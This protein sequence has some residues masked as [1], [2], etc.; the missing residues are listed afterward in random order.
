MTLDIEDSDF[1]GDIFNVDTWVNIL[2]IY[3]E[4]YFDAIMTDGG[5]F[6]VKRDDFIVRIKQRLLKD[7][8]YIYNYT[9]VIGKQV[10]DPM[11]RGH[12]FYKIPKREYTVFNHDR[13][14]RHYKKRGWGDELK[15]RM[16]L[17][18]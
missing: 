4:K 10:D 5:L 17:I 18:I 11:G 13:A 1:V 7:D 6:G 3:N 2:N 9:S 8:G 12:T 15:C 14:W 16:R